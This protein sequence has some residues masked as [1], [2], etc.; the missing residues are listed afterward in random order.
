MNRHRD[1]PPPREIGRCGACNAPWWVD[2]D[3]RE[4]GCVTD[5]CPGYI[6]RPVRQR[7]ESEAA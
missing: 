4:Q 6:D 5:G 7:P 1:F 2:D 3:D